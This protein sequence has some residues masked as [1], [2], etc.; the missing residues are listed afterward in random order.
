MKHINR[1]MG[2][3]KISIIAGV[4]FTLVVLHGCTNEEPFEDFE[5]E[6]QVALSLSTQIASDIT[7]TS[8]APIYGTN[9]PAG[10]DGAAENYDLG[11]W[12]C[13][14]EEYPTD[15]ISEKG[16]YNH[17]QT[18]LTVSGLDENIKRE[19]TFHYKDHAATT[20][21]VAKNKPIDIY[22]YYPMLTNSSIDYDNLRP[23]AVPFTTGESDWMWGNVSVDASE[24]TDTVVDIKMSYAHAMTCIR[25]YVTALYSASQINSITL[26]KTS[27]GLYKK[28]FL[29]LAE[30]K[31]VLAESDNSQELTVNYDRY[32]GQY[33]TAFY[34]IMPPV[35][36]FS[37]GEMS[38][39]FKIK[40]TIVPTK[41]TIPKQ[42]SNGQQVN[43][44]EQGKCYTYKLTVDNTISFSAV[45]V[46][47]T[48]IWKE[49]EYNFVL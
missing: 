37:D 46:D 43:G 15:F 8:R 7:V 45:D 23:D 27:G 22:S 11:T 16:G 21:N 31:L 18:R 33:Q 25:I 13:K 44:F 20:L 42:M 29:N 35:A 14:H 4:I 34:I 2:L 10:K 30:K 38:M 1:M 9:F 19:T 3:Y 39:T 36:S 12:I 48:G 32:I 17:L 47:E 49:N 24:L 26:G 5:D 40:N 28:G 41:F 6:D